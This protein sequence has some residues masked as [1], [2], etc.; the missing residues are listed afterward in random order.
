MEPSD[1]LRGARR[2][3][4]IEGFDLT[5]DLIWNVDIKKWVFRFL[6]HSSHAD[7]SRIPA[8]TSWFCTVDRN[9][10]QGNIKVYPDA[11]GGI[12]KTHYHQNF[13][14]LKEDH[15]WRK[16]DICIKDTLGKWG[17]RNFNEEPYDEKY[18]LQWYIKR[19]MEWIR[20]VAENTIVI[21]GDPFEV[22]ATPSLSSEKFVFNETETSFATW[23]DAATPF[24]GNC[25]FKEIFPGSNTF[26]ISTFKAKDFEMSYEW[27]LHINEN[28]KESDGFWIRLKSVPVFE[29]WQLPYFWNELFEVAAKDQIDLP[30]LIKQILYKA[31][32]SFFLLI[33]F[34]IPENFGEENTGYHWMGVRCPKLTK[35]TGFRDKSPEQIN[36]S[37]RIAF[38]A[39]AKIDWLTTES[40]SFEDLTSRGKLDPATIG[41][42]YL[43]IGA[44]A[45]GSCLGELLVRLG[46]INVT[47][48]DHDI[49]LA[50]NLVRHTLTMEEAYRFKAEAMATHLNKLSPHA[51]VKHVSKSITSLSSHQLSE[52]ISDHNVIINATANDEVIDLFD[53]LL[54][55]QE[56]T[57]V[58]FAFGF[59][60][61]RMFCFYHHNVPSLKSTFLEKIMPW[62]DKEAEENP[63]P[64]FP[65]EGL[66]CWHPVFPA[67]LDHI[68]SLIGAEMTNF[69]KLMNNPPGTDFHVMERSPENGSISLKTDVQ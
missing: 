46:C 48:I 25:T 39:T 54:E 8:T 52:L 51:K 18:R 11:V 22:P 43:L 38:N 17:K 50:G 55:G 59:F 57:F 65:R 40:W 42:Q 5:E 56:K 37:F 53:E 4:F 12:E 34:P 33:G 47:V 35:L 6:I 23:N 68:Q 49:V 66:G 36:T 13:N 19:C 44:G 9:Y 45:L 16:G 60:V 24:G 28:K 27:G 58:S 2:N 20:A 14:S 67:R 10:P 29:E 41:K 31:K 7:T 3:C 62:L 64:D 21:P 63:D 61:K 69:E 1:A 26:V 15:R 32:G 30:A